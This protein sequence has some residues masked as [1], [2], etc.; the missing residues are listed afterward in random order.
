MGEPMWNPKQQEVLDSRNENNDILVSAAAGSG[1]TAVMIERILRGIIE[2]KF[3]VDELLVM[4]FTNSAAAQMRRKMEKALTKAAAESQDPDLMEQLA[5]VGQADF[6][7]ID[8]FCNRIVR[9]NFQVLGIDPA[10][11]LF[12]ANEKN[13][14]YSEVLTDV[15]HTELERNPEMRK[16]AEFFMQSNI[17]DDALI[18]IVMNIS[19]KADSF[20]NPASW[21]EGALKDVEE[22]L[23]TSNWIQLFLTQMHQQVKAQLAQNQ[24]YMEMYLDVMATNPDLDFSKGQDMVSKDRSIL[25][26][27]A[28]AESY[29]EMK[30]ALDACNASRAWPSFNAGKG[31]KE[32]PEFQ[33]EMASYKDLRGIWKKFW[34]KKNMPSIA[35]LEQEQ[36]TTG[37]MIFMLLE[38]A[39][40][41]DQALMEEKM[42]LKKFDFSDIEH[43]AYQIL[44][45]E[46]DHARTA[47]GERV[48]QDYRYIYVDEYQDSSDLQEHILKAIARRE[49]GLSKNIFMVGD[50]KQ[51]IY[52]FRDA[53]PDL[54]AG[55]SEIFAE[56]RSQ[57]H[58]ITLNQNYRSRKEILNATNFICSLLIQKDF[59]G[60][61]YDD[62]VA[63]HPP[64]EDA[65]LA[66]FPDAPE[67]NVG[68]KVKCI[69][70]D[71]SKLEDEEDS[72]TSGQVETPGQENPGQETADGRADNQQDNSALSAAT[73][74]QQEA[75]VIAREIKRLMGEG[76]EEAF[77]VKNDDYDPSLPESPENAPYRR[78]RYQDITILQRSLVGA[79]EMA[80]VYEAAGIPVKVSDSTG[81]FDAEEII[82]LL[83]ALN[84]INNAYD[85]I[86]L[87]TF[88]LSKPI[89]IQEK[90][91][92]DIVA[93]VRSA[94]LKQQI[95]GDFYM[96][97]T[98]K[99]YVDLIPD[100]AEPSQLDLRNHVRDI[101]SH[102]SAWRKDAI[103]LSIAELI[104]R[105]IRDTNLDLYVGALPEGKRRV[106]NLRQLG[107]IAEKFDANLGG[108]LFD[109][110]RYM[111]KCK[112]HEYDFGEADTLDDD[113]VVHICSMHKSKGLEYP[114]VFI[115]K[116][117]KLYNKM[118]ATGKCIVDSE[119]HVAL[120][121]MKHIGPGYKVSLPSFRKQC[122]ADLMVRRQLEEEVRILY[123]AMTR[124]KE[125]LIIT[126]CV[127]MT[128]PHGTSIDF[129]SASKTPADF[130]LNGLEQDGA[131]S[132]FS[133]EVIHYTQVQEAY[134]NE[135]SH[136]NRMRRLDKDTLE[137][138]I[139]AEMQS[140]LAK[141]EEERKYRPYEYPYLSAA[142]QKTKLS[143]SEVKHG[144][145]DAEVEKNARDEK[146]T[147]IP[148]K[149]VTIPFA[150]EIEKERRMRAG[151]SLPED[152]NSSEWM[153]S[154]VEAGVSPGALRGT[155]MHRL[156][157]L[158]P[159]E[160]INS[161]ADFDQEVKSLF[162]GDAFSQE[163]REVNIGQISRFYSEEEN[164]IFQNMKKASVA[165]KLRREQQFLIGLFPNEI[166]SG[167]VAG[168]RI[169]QSQGANTDL[170]RITMQGE[171]DAFYFDEENAITLVD[172]KTDN[173]DSPE[174]LI[175]LYAS[176]MYL[177]KLAL[178]KL[179]ACPVHDIIL[180]SFKFGEIHCLEQVMETV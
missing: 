22:D 18:D 72:Q 161:Q 11:D 165:G 4:T 169:A 3:N 91:L 128:K 67:L 50:V 57:G 180:Y 17:K 7:T 71:Q 114:V 115:A 78:L 142:R 59:G 56:D 108:G 62:E 153:S 119:Y 15:I 87:T 98:C 68:G 105:I 143:V 8:S 152:D 81:Y 175:S 36:E 96:L 154:D 2:K 63:L 144:R 133:Q 60:I 139:H 40:K 126:G 83:A 77:Q 141:P 167:N 116:T 112:I 146:E 34:A 29:E 113:D 24:K 55:K 117:G 14:V 97:D 174:K 52:S 53:R 79:T 129:I 37:K 28:D 92:A 32:L 135:L 123:V 46:A 127:D 12:D 151:N 162:Q 160:K 51:S 66:H 100:D 155:V 106:A 102:I 176:Q 41:F 35:Y 134:A 159:Y 43:F 104:T 156:L 21:Y 125:K 130:L 103:H 171:I 121:L 178:E 75:Y 73:K 89:G 44:Y 148:D 101:L 54:F 39:R 172:Y 45:S 74:G 140:V 164:S 27:I 25:L 13:L 110:L 69:W 109:F 64:K 93:K 118:D 138:A 95:K 31:A 145:M 170:D 168:A 147:Q 122:V 23:L 70:I 6:V 107:L 38:L 150:E 158:L 124:A 179:T 157:E 10:F 42:R 30:S 82:V 48:S 47:I 88:I 65:Y 173:V 137:K 33:E 80:A 131:G 111:E 49:N 120:D 85:D 58:L 84:V 20:A 136:E 76:D 86:Q 149:D 177:Y 1:K 90:D 132:F 26:N 16:M 94:R 99:F 163:E 61:V 19:G 5:L 166:P 9:E